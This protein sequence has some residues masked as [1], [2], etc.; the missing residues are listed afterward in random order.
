MNELMNQ[1]IRRTM[2]ELMN[3]DMRR[4]M[5]EWMNQGMRRM[6]NEWMNQGMRR[7]MN[8]L[9][10]QD[11]RRMM[12]EWMNQD[13]IGGW[14]MSEWIKIWEG[15]WMSEWIMLSM[16]GWYLEGYEVTAVLNKSPGYQLSP[17][18]LLFN[19]SLD[20]SRAKCWPQKVWIKEKTKFCISE[21]RSQRPLL[22][23]QD[24][25]QNFTFYPFLATILFKQCLVNWN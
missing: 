4:I 5:N 22:E 19:C 8:E 7:M 23:K 3:Q 24:D 18:I 20:I 14:W 2:N 15:W 11:M 16:K 17:I 6:M 10:N 1:D 13:I 9:M 12:N 21:L 25:C